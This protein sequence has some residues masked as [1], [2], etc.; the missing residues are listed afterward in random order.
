MDFD[1][2]LFEH[3]DVE[4][5]FLEIQ[6]KAFIQERGFNPSSTLCNEIWE[7]ANCHRW[8]DLWLT[9][10]ELTVISV[11]Q[12]FYTSLKYI[13]NTIQQNDIHQEVT[14]RVKQE[15]IVYRDVDLLVHGE[16]HQWLKGKDILPSPCDGPM[17]KSEGSDDF[18]RTIYKANK[19]WRLNFC[20]IPK[21]Q[22][23]KILKWNQKRKQ[24][25]N[26]PPSLKRNSKVAKYQGSQGQ[27]KMPH[28]EFMVRWLHEVQPLYNNYVRRHGVWM[29]QFS[30][31]K[32]APIL[33]HGQSEEEKEK[34]EQTEEDF[35][36]VYNFEKAVGRD[37]VKIRMIDSLEFESDED[38]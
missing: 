37:K 3:Q 27:N 14:V 6:G 2:S 8:F 38:Y 13:E 12:E 24:K 25:I 7:L 36:P 34:G 20:I 17:P 31:C 23:R 35:P 28:W 1:T 9:P 21:L 10:K 4:K 11:D 32:Y 19:E 30:P 16:V 22:R 15:D 26:K 18:H 33:L 29:S 5:Y